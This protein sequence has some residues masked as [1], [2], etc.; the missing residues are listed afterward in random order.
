MNDYLESLVDFGVIFVV[1]LLGYFFYLGR[2]FIRII[3][4]GNRARAQTAILGLVLL[5]FSATFALN[6]SSF[7]PEFFHIA[8]FAHILAGVY[9]IGLCS[10]VDRSEE[11]AP[12]TTKNQ[13]TALSAATDT[14]ML[15]S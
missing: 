12:L 15:V 2:F 1:I 14:A 11:S 8:N 13:P 5:S 10:K 3:R 7:F 6:L 9:A 4:N